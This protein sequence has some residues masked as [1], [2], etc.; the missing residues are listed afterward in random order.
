MWESS[1]GLTF[2]LKTPEKKAKERFLCLRIDVDGILKKS[3]IKRK[4]DV[5]RWD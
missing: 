2:F 4:W 5:T 3:S 1:F